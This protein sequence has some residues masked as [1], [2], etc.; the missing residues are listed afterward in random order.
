MD[1]V[2]HLPEAHHAGQFHHLRRRQHF[3]QSRHHFLRHFRGIDGGGAGVGHAGGF[4][5]RQI[6]VFRVEDFRHVGVAVAPA[7][8]LSRGALLQRAGVV[9]HAVGA[10]V[11]GAA[12][13][14]YAPLQFRAEMAARVA[15]GG[16]VDVDHALHDLR[17]VH[18]ELQGVGQKAHAFD[19]VRQGLLQVLRQRFHLRV[20]DDRVGFPGWRFAHLASPASAWPGVAVTEPRSST[21]RR[22]G[23]NPRVA[24][25]AA[26]GADTALTSASEYPTAPS[27]ANR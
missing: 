25:K 4:H 11:Q 3:R 16:V 5:V 7:L 20:G 15:H 17:A 12:Q 1:G 19:V 8:A 21:A 24:T 6:G 18:V 22:N 2:V 10:V 27:S 23:A 13:H 26:T 14:R 9:R